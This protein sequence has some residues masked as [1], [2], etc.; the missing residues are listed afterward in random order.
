MGRLAQVRREIKVVH[1]LD[2]A[3]GGAANLPSTK[4]GARFFNLADGL[5]LIAPTAGRFARLR[6]LGFGQAESASRKR[7]HN[8]KSTGSR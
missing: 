2:R 7:A 3:A 1:V 4:K 5:I 6:L 8:W